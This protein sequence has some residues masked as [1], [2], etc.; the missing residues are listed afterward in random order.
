MNISELE[1]EQAQPLAR[2]L[3]DRV[4]R[5]AGQIGI[6]GRDQAAH[7]AAKGVVEHERLDGVGAVRSQGVSKWLIVLDHRVQ[8]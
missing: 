4:G 2:R 3:L 7:A 1:P 5:A 6:K 8:N